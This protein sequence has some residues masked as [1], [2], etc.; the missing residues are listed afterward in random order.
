M[1]FFLIK[2]DDWE[3]PRYVLRA[4]L[5]IISGQSSDFM[6]PENTRKPFVFLYSQGVYRIRN[7][8]VMIVPLPRR[9]REP[10]MAGTIFRYRQYFNPKKQYHKKVPFKKIIKSVGIN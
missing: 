3:T 7:F 5:T 9:Y 6:P 4:A 2:K 1:N 8:A 10:Q